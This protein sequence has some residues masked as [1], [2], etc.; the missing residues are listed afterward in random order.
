MK[1]HPFLIAGAHGES[2]KSLLNL[3]GQTLATL[4]ATGGDNG[5][6]TAGLHA[7]EEAVSALATGS[8]RLVSTLHDKEF[9]FRNGNKRVISQEKA[10]L[11]N[12]KF[13]AHLWITLPKTVRMSKLN[14]PHPLRNY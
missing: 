2:D 1:I 7:N 5:A 3:Y 13:L 9:L 8:G 14:A 11:V 4:G 6:A 12:G 10:P